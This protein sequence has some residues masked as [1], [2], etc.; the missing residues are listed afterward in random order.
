MGAEEEEALIPI[1]L[2][3]FFGRRRGADRPRGAAPRGR[4]GRAGKPL[5]RRALEIQQRALGDVAPRR[6]GDQ[7]RAGSGVRHWT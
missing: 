3:L 4:E 7:G 1:Q 5:L 6:R 2:F